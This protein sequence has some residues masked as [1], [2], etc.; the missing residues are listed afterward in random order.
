M[1]TLL[2][3]LCIALASCASPLHRETAKVSC[4]GDYQN[5]KCSPTGVCT[6]CTNCHS[7]GHCKG[8]GK[9]SVCK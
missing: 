3:L 6:A 4:C 2:P 9:C 7:C 8:G 1:K 5:G